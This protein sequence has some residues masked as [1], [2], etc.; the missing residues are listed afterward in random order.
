MKVILLQDVAKVGK[1]FDVKEV[2]A[3]YARNMLVP[4]GLAKP[5]TQEALRWV[6]AHRKELEEK[7]AKEMKTAQELAEKMKGQEIRIR[8]KAGEKGQTFSSVGAKQIAER[9]KE[10]R[11]EIGS[12]QIILE[13]PIKSVGEHPVRVRLGN[14]ME[15]ELNVV[16]EEE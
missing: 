6:E 5:A 7:A 2:A 16:V 8:V 11:Y 4:R 13:E 9:L 12:G 1:R 10:E 3:G 14:D 15:V